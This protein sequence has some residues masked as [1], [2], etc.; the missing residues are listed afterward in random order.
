MNFCR[1]KKLKTKLDIESKKN[2][3][4]SYNRKNN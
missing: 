1:T 2:N 3:K 4:K